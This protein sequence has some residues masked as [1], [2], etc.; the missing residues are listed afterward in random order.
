M[1]VIRGTVVL[2]VVVV[3][4]GRIILPLVPAARLVERAQRQQSRDA[5]SLQGRFVC[6]AVG[7]GSDAAE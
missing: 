1:S 3:V 2:R 4:E 5:A 6:T 7:A